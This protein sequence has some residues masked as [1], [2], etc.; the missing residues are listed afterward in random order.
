MKKIALFTALGA[1]CLVWAGAAG[2]SA[3]HSVQADG[4]KIE[5]ARVQPR[6]ASLDI[7]FTVNYAGLNLSTYQELRLQPVVVAGRD[8]AY[9]PYLVL[10]GKARDK[11]NHRREAL[12]GPK[13][14]RE[15]GLETG[16]QTNPQAV[17]ETSR[18]TGRE[19]SRLYRA[20]RVRRGGQPEV[21]HYTASLPFREW[22]PDARLELMR[23]LSGCDDCKQKLPSLLIGPVEKT[24]A[25]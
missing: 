11:M 3:Q 2:I 6:G 4:L 18:A 10:A 22:M 12:Y 13:A 9:M 17:P 20:V 14:G 23:T 19:A 21:I 15:T 8:T 16:R 1:V 25:E 5:A 7:D 24:L